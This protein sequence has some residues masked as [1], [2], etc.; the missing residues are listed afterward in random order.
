MISG[1]GGVQDYGTL[2]VES[3]EP[4][5][6]GQRRVISAHFSDPAHVEPIEYRYE[7]D[8]IAI[9]D[10]EVRALRPNATV[11][12][13]A[14]TAHHSAQFTVHTVEDADAFHIRFVTVMVGED[15]VPLEIY[16]ETNKEPIRFI[17][18]EDA[19]C[20]DPAAR[21]VVALRAGKWMIEAQTAQTTTWFWVEAFER[22]PKDPR[23]MPWDEDYQKEL[24]A[25]AQSEMTPS[26]TVFIGDS[27]FDSRWFWTDF[28]DTYRGKDALCYGL[29]G[30]TAYDWMDLAPKLFAGVKP[31][32]LVIN[33]GTNHLY[34]DGDSTDRA[35][36][37]LRQWFEQLH[38]LLPDT[39]IYYF[40][41][42]LRSYASPAGDTH[43]LNEATRKWCE[44]KDWI[45]YLDIEAEMTADRLLDGIHPKEYSSYIAALEKSG[46]VMAEKSPK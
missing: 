8:A 7:G 43:Q 44:G 37:A 16:P 38:K 35:A 1:C 9:V 39:K 46:L 14:K 28:Y 10:G 30:A 22:D 33:L 34:D 18:A 25:R 20:F 12:V 21:T 45:I 3:M 17:G 40:S 4:L 6:V 23:W 31:A 5:A 11:S 41:V 15:P 24:I 36:A 42:A 2:T 19:L 26:S 29:A 27:F 32:N 13:T